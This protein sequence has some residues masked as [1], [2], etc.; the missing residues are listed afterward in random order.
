MKAL[1]FGATGYVGAA[2]AR[3]LRRR[4]YD[5]HGVARTPSHHET[6]GAAHVVPVD[7]ALSDS[8]AVRSLVAGYNA[9]VFAAMM[10]WTEEVPLLEAILSG[11]EGGKRVFLYTSGTGVLSLPNRMGEWDENCFAED[12]PFPFQPTPDS[13][14]RLRN[15]RMVRDASD[16]QLRTIVVRPPLIWGNAGSIQIPRMFDSALKTGA[17]CYLGRGLNLY[18]NVHVD[19]LAEVYALAAERGPP[20][21]LYHA[22]AGEANFRSLAE[23]ISAATGCPTRSIDYAQ[24]CDLWGAGWVDLAIAVNSRSTSP[25]ARSDLG[26][27][28][29]HLDVVE[30]IRNGSYRAMFEAREGWAAMGFTYTGA[31][32]PAS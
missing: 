9:V 17:V 4:G 22:V 8:S 29:V 12:D 11:V 31:H 32:G 6:L 10:T 20:G 24:A 19:D 15:E 14:I 7:C 3:A 21:A 5:V 26:W 23:A 28:P 1:I 27:N 30:D 13:V 2:V 25:R 16:G 18:S